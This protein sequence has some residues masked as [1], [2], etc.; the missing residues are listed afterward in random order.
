M[1]NHNR[2]PKAQ[3]R[4][5]PRSLL[6]SACD[7]VKFWMLHFHDMIFDFLGDEI[8]MDMSEVYEGRHLSSN[9]NIKTSPNQQPKRAKE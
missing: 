5:I 9:G 7:H 6:Q 3:S 2:E 1:V 8:K 4:T